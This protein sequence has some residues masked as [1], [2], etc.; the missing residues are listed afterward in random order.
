MPKSRN[1]LK[2]AVQDVAEALPDV[3][4]QPCPALGLDLDGCVDEAPIFFRILTR[5]WP[6]Q[7]VVITFRRDRAKAEEDLAR[8]DIRYTDLTLVNSLDAKAEVIAEKGVLVYFDDQ[9]ETLKDIP[10][11]VNVMLVRNGGNF[12]FE[13]RHWLFSE[14]TGRLV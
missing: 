5:A 8:F 7:V 14:E 11:T 12:D 2:D 1:H 6:G 4:D 10:A 13:S 3:M 9:P